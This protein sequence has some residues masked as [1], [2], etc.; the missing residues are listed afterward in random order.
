MTTLLIGCPVQN[1]AWILPDWLTYAATAADIAGYD[2]PQYLFVGDPANDPDTFDIINQL[3][4]RATIVVAPDVSRPNDVRV[5]NE[6]RFHRMVELRNLLLGEV[7]HIAPDLFLSL[8]SDILLH[9][10]GLRDSIP[11]TDGLDHKGRGPFATVGLL[12]YMTRKGTSTPSYGL[13][14]REGQLRRVEQRGCFPVDVVM[15]AK[16][17][18]PAAYSINYVYDRLGEDIGWSKEVTANGLQICF[19]GRVASKHVMKPEDLHEFDE[20]CGF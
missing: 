11:V 1:R 6:S 14:S 15:A 5:W 9:P 13:F 12:C 2:D 18:T 17:M 7:R 19:D 16:I 10:D 3:G 8:D 20:R 4:G